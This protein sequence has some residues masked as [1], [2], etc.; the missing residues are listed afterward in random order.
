[1]NDAQIKHMVDR[2]LGWKLPESFRP[3]NGI[4]FKP[5]FNDHLPTPTKHNPVGTNLLDAREA[6]EMVKHL[7]QGLP[8][9]GPG[10]VGAAEREVGRYVYRRIEALMDARA[11]TPEGAELTYLVNIA[12]SVE[13]YGEDACAGQDLQAPTTLSGPQSNEGEGT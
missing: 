11:D 6:T 3:D 5:T 13:E 12:A 1:M 9:G 8:D 2:F 7:I 10:D 4:S